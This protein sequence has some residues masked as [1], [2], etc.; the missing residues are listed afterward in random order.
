MSNGFSLSNEFRNQAFMDKFNSMANSMQTSDPRLQELLNM[1]SKLILGQTMNGLSPNWQTG[2][3]YLGRA[4]VNSPLGS[5]T[6]MANGADSFT[7]YHNAII[8]QGA[9]KMQQFGTGNYGYSYGAG[10]NTLGL[11]YHLNQQTAQFAR[12]AGLDT[13][14]AAGF[15]AANI[16]NN[17]LEWG[18]VISYGGSDVTSSSGI[19]ALYKSLQGKAPD[20]VRNDIARAAVISKAHEKFI[21]ENLKLEESNKGKDDAT[22]LKENAALIPVLSRN[23]KRMSENNTAELEKRLEAA[24]TDLGYTKLDM[25]DATSAE[26]DAA[27]ATRVTGFS[28][29][30]V[31]PEFISKSKAA[32]NK[33][34]D[35]LKS[36][37]EIF[38]TKNF[39][40]L[41]EITKT[42]QM[43][44]F[45]NENH[46]KKMGERIADAKRTALVTNRDVKD[47]LAEQG[48]I[49]DVLSL[50]AG[51]KNFVNDKDISHWQNVKA[52]YDRNSQRGYDYR[53]EAEFG[54]DMASSAA[55]RRQLFGDVMVGSYLLEKKGDLLNKTIGGTNETYASRIQGLVTKFK[56]TTDRSEQRNINDQIKSLLKNFGSLISDQ[57]RREAYRNGTLDLNAA[58]QPGLIAQNSELIA[59]EIFATADKSVT[60]GLGGEKQVASMLANVGHVFGSDIEKA[61]EFLAAVAK[62]DF[63]LKLYE[64]A[65]MD[66]DSL[67]RLKS[68]A[69]YLKAG[70]VN[71]R[72]TFMQASNKAQINGRYGRGTYAQLEAENAATEKFFSDKQTAYQNVA[73]NEKNAFFAALLGD[74]NELT[75]E[76]ALLAMQA[77]GAMGVYFAGDLKDGKFEGNLSNDARKLLGLDGVDTSKYTQ[78]DWYKAFS[79]AEQD[80]V[81]IATDARGMTFVTKKD[82][83][84]LDKKDKISKETDKLKGV[85]GLAK[86]MAGVNNISLDDKG[87]L[88][89]TYER[90]GKKEKVEGR[91]A[92]ADIISLRD[93][94]PEG[95]A[96][97]KEFIENSKDPGTKA[98]KDELKEYETFAGI[99]K[100]TGKKEIDADSAIYKALPEFFN[101]YKSAF[102][103]NDEELT[104]DLKELGLQ[105]MFDSLQ[106]EDPAAAKA[107]MNGTAFNAINQLAGKDYGELRAEGIID[108]DNKF[109]SKMGSSLEGKNATELVNMMKNAMRKEEDPAK[110]LIT[111]IVNMLKALMSGSESLKVKMA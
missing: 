76:G 81:V 23:F 92:L 62:P 41:D 47:V 78:K 89:I 39:A 42:L 2:F 21:L 33:H 7:A 26:I 83:Y 50:A 8:Q 11:A 80:G 56:S 72:S 54:A 12:G 48:S 93:S 18:D 24:K 27:M 43:G 75:D 51:G 60:E 84:F 16:Q 96:A 100:Y 65:G 10:S 67:D 74:S 110:D 19:A 38:D 68:V 66:K 36:L 52:I 111:Q 46:V 77:Q 59:Q 31:S 63:S 17:G 82:E 86:H 88:A 20:N 49:M 13:S 108:A 103:L 5:M 28:Y 104:A 30:G 71:R 79:K 44:S 9:L 34:A 109:T 45:Q 37:S 69:D 99:G 98:L 53:T 55:N 61:N 107:L 87:N 102:G 1:L 85:A 22:L 57:D 106:V 3:E 32:L 90:N 95:Y 70:G 14:L 25:R 97:Y 91:A 64:N 101:V 94:S 58:T 4:I 15:L 40:E 105:S 35:N 6:G 73:F 29:T